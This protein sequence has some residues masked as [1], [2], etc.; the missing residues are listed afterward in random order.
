MSAKMTTKYNIEKLM[1]ER[2]L[3]LDGAMG[4]MIQ[5]KDPEE[6]DYRGV[7]FKN[8]ETDQ[9]GNNELLNLTQPEMIKGIHNRY[10]EAG[11]DIIE[12]NTFNANTISLDE[13]DMGD[14]V[15][16]INEKAAEIAIASKNE[17]DSIEKPRFVAG[18]IGPTN[19]T[20]S[21]SPVVDNPGYRDIT[22]DKLVDAYA[23][24]IE[25]L[26]DGGVD[27][28]LVET[29]FD[30][31]NARAAVYAIN[32]LI[33]KKQKDIPVMLSFTINDASGRMLTGQSIRA[34][35]NTV[36]QLPLVTLGM[37]CAFGAQK[38]LPF[39]KELKEVS[40]FF[41][42][43]HPNAGLPNALGEY[44]QS[45]EE[46]IEKLEP[47]FK[48][49]LVNIAG[50]CC[51]TKPEHIKLIAQK[52]KQYRP[53]QP[54]QSKK[55]TIISGLD[56]LNIDQTK[57][58]IK[59]GERTNVMGSRKFLKLIQEENYEEALEIARDQV[60]NGAQM[61]NV[62][63]DEAM[64][65]GKAAMKNFLRILVSEPGLAVTPVMIDSSDFDILTAGLKN[66]PGKSIVN[67]ISLK[68]G[69]TDFLKK[70]QIIKDFGAAVVVMA[71]D[72]KGQAITYDR[73]IEICSRSYN[74]LTKKLGFPP[75]DIVFDPNV[76][77]IATGMSE[78]NRYGIDFIKACEWIKENLPH[79]KISGGISNLSFAFRGNPVLRNA[80][81]SV[82][83]HHAVKAGLD[84][85]IVNPAKLQDYN[86]IPV[87]L[88]KAVEDVIFDKDEN[89]TENLIEFKNLHSPEKKEKS[90]QEE[91]RNKDPE[92]RILHA[93]IEG[94][95]RYL[96][97]D[98]EALRAEYD[99]P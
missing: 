34:F 38:L 50:G 48:A 82:F 62:N 63:M 15:Y 16:E 91:W 42:T 85:A 75:E 79:A 45:P 94:D 7:R 51:G 84:M 73:K 86:D 88:R 92:S 66:L 12:T 31:I 14:L 87:D 36:S 43:V 11:A 40:P 57:S 23:S 29:M 69:E 95:T 80:M 10:L 49:S 20:A 64:I 76:L 30:A 52:A 46:M 27:L 9:K 32:S 78:H 33:K 19:K 24:Q 28:L 54:T 13:Y 21:I 2:I 55:Q 77:T 26:I 56:T 67:S 18:V 37:N 89:A 98:L 47:Y 4:T 96:T 44:D 74:L 68:E 6:N 65:D 17:Y 81:N 83:L 58:F 59:I 53:P 22:F 61:L 39:V 97:D 99:N 90:K 60:E 71:F 25:G 1:R 5:S 72:E 41:T 70:A 8:K 93:L 35:V 3:I